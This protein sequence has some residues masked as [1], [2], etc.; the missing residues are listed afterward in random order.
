MSIGGGARPFLGAGPDGIILQYYSKMQLPSPAALSTA[1][2][3]L[4]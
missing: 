1:V 4:T 3:Y 2:I